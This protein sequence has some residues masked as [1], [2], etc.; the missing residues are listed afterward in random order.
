MATG[1]RRLAVFVPDQVAKLQRKMENEVKWSIQLPV[2]DLRLEVFSSGFEPLI[3]ALKTLC[4]CLEIHLLLRDRPSLSTCALQRGIQRFTVA[5]LLATGSSW[6]GWSSSSG[7]PPSYCD[8]ICVSIM[9]AFAD[10]IL[11]APGEQLETRVH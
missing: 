7:T 9:D 5:T 8:L 2:G 6:P 3:H 1:A 11:H 10:N 4:S